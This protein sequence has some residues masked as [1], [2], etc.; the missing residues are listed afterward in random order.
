MPDYG[1]APNGMPTVPFDLTPDLASLE[2]PWTLG[3]PFGAAEQGAAVQLDPA[4]AAALAPVPPPGDPAGAPGPAGDQ[5]PAA[6]GTPAAVMAAAA[7]PPPDQPIAHLADLQ[8]G[9]GLPAAALAAAAAPG[10]PGTGAA[11]PP[12]LPGAAAPAAPAPPV[13]PGALVGAPTAAP[14]A[15]PADMAAAGP[16]PAT[17]MW[18]PPFDDAL[19]GPPAPPPLPPD[20]A[21]LPPVQP[22]PPIDALTGA[23]GM[24]PVGALGG[25][26]YAATLTPEQH[27]RQ[28][29][30]A[31]QG[32]SPF[33][34]QGNVRFSND[35]EAQ[36]YINDLALRDAPAAAQ[37]GAQLEDIR[38]KRYLAQQAKNENANWEQQ[39]ANIRMRNQA[40][41]DAQR[42]TDAL[43][44]DAQRIADTKIDPTGGL[45]TGGKIAGV[46]AAVIGGLVQG[47]TGSAHNAGLEA[48]T[49]T[50]NRSIDAQKATLANQLTGI[51]IR[52]GALADEYARHGDEYL[53]AETMRVAA[54]K[55]ADDLLALEQQKYTPRGMTFL[56][57]AGLRAGIT[58]QIQAAIDARHSK[59]VEL[60][61]KIQNAERELLIANETGRHNRA[62][63]AKD[64][65][66][67]DIER[68]KAK[69]KDEVYAPDVLG[70]I[71]PPGVP[72]PPVPMSIKEY[73]QWAESAD[74]GQQFVNQSR[75]NTHA[76][77]SVTVIDPK[78]G[79]A[80]E[81]I[82]KGT[83]EEIGKLKGKVSAT[84]KIVNLID[85]AVRKRTGWAS[86]VGNSDEKQQL[87][88][89]WGQA[90]IEA[91]NA[92]DLGQ[93]TT[94]DVELIKGMLGTDNPSKLRNPVP[95]MIE[96]RALLLQ[97]LNTDLQSK[98]Y[99]KDQKYDI[100]AP[101][102]ALED[103]DRLTGR[104]AIEQGEDARPVI[105]G[106]NK[107][108][109]PL[110]QGDDVTKRARLIAE[111]SARVGP[112]G[113]ALEDDAKVRAAIA[114]A[115]DATPAERADVV[116]KL[117]GWAQSPRPSVASGVL[118]LLRG[119]SPALYEQVVAKLPAKQ[120]ADI[121]DWEHL[122]L[123]GADL[124]PPA[125]LHRPP[126]IGEAN[127]TSPLPPPPP[128]ADGISG[129]PPGW[130]EGE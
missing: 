23:G 61:L 49:D 116:A 36:R 48:L 83:P 38:L 95:G 52:R 57:I 104:T 111:G 56:K 118:G 74:K 96:A 80:S 45:S 43:L 34:E 125:S 81:F 92:A 21:A 70:R 82:A 24:P 110:L 25:D 58:G 15:S 79:Q 76:V 39:Q 114:L 62:T 54:F 107:D 103:R 63:E 94:S 3:G 124:P 28:A 98:G 14:P 6:G 42:K 75:S 85:E 119:E 59:D 101:P 86:D 17:P 40:L 69:A 47:R 11:L 31:L 4:T 18:P 127:A 50:I 55:H 22:L 122:P 37:Y 5:A 73:G 91:K 109:H 72:L 108:A 115:A 10:G 87:D 30:A 123:P 97:G 93:I 126:P 129:A 67:L 68:N 113:L 112:T 117:A 120:R 64:W 71:L 78:T 44:A 51:G 77:P 20:E 65:A 128:V 89:I 7:P 46:L 130:G 16:A 84:T 90:K 105:F 13:P 66:Q 100:P 19:T 53:A 88:A 2:F 106:G 33:D 32:G 1:D 9:I 121:P 8:P 99:P 41:A 29:V 35:A 60:S 27:Y 26:P 12:G 102:S